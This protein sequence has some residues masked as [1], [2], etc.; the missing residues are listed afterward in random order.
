[1]AS[2]KKEMCRIDLSSDAL[3][4]AENGKIRVK[5]NIFQ[6]KQANF[7]SGLV[8]WKSLTLANNEI[9][10]LLQGAKSTFFEYILHSAGL[11]NDMILHSLWQDNALFY[12]F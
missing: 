11:F 6:N 3:E 5:S 9:A 1:M 10:K 8:D 12:I 4:W 2:K 7:L